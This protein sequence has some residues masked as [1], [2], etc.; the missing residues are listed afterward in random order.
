MGTCRSC[1]Q[2]LIPCLSGGQVLEFT[3]RHCHL[4][5]A[6]LARKLNTWASCMSEAWCLITEK[7]SLACSA[8]HAVP[9][10]AV[11]TWMQNRVSAYNLLPEQRVLRPDDPKV[12][13]HCSQRRCGCWCYA[14]VCCCGCA[15]RR[16]PR[17]RHSTRMRPGLVGF[18][19]RAGGRAHAACTWPVRRPKGGAVGYEYCLLRSRGMQSVELRLCK[20]LGFGRLTGLE[21]AVA[22]ACSL[23]GLPG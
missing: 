21:G 15:L 16:H 5:S 6:R 22:H 8:Q 20:A 2:T 14:G 23:L 7:C 1:R 10:C 19:W 4:T 11:C 9:S 17:A 12:P 18:V 13:M 3:S